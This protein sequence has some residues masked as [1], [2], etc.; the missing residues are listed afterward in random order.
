MKKSKITT[1]YP[2]FGT[3]E[4]GIPQNHIY[5]LNSKKGQFVTKEKAR[6]LCPERIN[7]LTSGEYVLCPICQTYKDG[8]LEINLLK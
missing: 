1:I 4:L 8:K 2:C 5:R 6:E 3:E 7:L